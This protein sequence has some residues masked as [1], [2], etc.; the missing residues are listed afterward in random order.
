M[1]NLTQIAEELRVLLSEL[2]AII[3][4]PKEDSNEFSISLGRD[5]YL[6]VDPYDYGAAQST[7]N[8]EFNYDNITIPELDKEKKE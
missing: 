4:E 8:F 3:G 2:D 6:H 5:N 1:K 7:M